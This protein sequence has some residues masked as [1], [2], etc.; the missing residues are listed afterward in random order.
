MGLTF[1]LS[2]ME[3]RWWG[4]KLV[5]GRKLTTSATDAWLELALL[6]STNIFKSMRV[7]LVVLFLVL[8]ILLTIN[9][10]LIYDGGVIRVLT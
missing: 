4:K 8:T 2:E 5:K 7:A 10:D 1:H 3:E 6:L 9:C